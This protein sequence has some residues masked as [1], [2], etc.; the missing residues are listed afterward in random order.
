MCCSCYLNL[1]ICNN[2]LLQQAVAKCPRHCK[3]T[4]YPPSSCKSP[5]TIISK[6]IVT[7]CKS[8]PPMYVSDFSKIN[9]HDL[10]QLRLEHRYCSIVWY[11]RCWWKQDLPAH[12]TTP[13]ALSIRFL[14]SLLFGLWSS[15]SAIAINR[16]ETKC[17]TTIQQ[18]HRH[19]ECNNCI[20]Y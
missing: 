10:W 13:P 7:I 2:K 9:R 17:L 18:V 3:Y 14:S 19:K 20:Q 12:I 15:E 1:R 11:S 6:M 5:F 8:P 4:T 16:R